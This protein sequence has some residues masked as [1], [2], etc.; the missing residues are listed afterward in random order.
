MKDSSLDELKTIGDLLLQK[1]HSGI[2]ILGTVTDRKPQAVIIVTKDLI[3]NGILA[4]NISREIGKSMGGGGG[5]KAHLATSGG[6]NPDKLKIA[7]DNGIEMAKTF[8]M[9]MKNE[10]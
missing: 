10:S 4:D 8:I 5:G 6:K 3:K 1:I 2:G 9:N 7:I